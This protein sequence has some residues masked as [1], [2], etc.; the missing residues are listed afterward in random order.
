MGTQG[1]LSSQNAVHFDSWDILCLW[2]RPS[3]ILSGS[4]T[5]T[6]TTT[7]TTSTTTTTTTTSSIPFSLAIAILM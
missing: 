7:S 3:V 4:P 6:S 5:F 2:N 1:L